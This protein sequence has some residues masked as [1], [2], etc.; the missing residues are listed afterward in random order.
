M[1]TP[2]MSALIRRRKLFGE[3][4][5]EFFLFLLLLFSG[6]VRSLDETLSIA[7]SIA[8]VLSHTLSLPPLSNILVHPLPVF[9]PL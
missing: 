3:F 9:V 2:A 8:L 5:I 1:A 7:L 6:V 4:L